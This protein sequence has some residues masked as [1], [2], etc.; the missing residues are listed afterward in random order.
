METPLS[1]RL[2]QFSYYLIFLAAFAFFLVGLNPTFY[3]DDSPETITACVTLGIPHPPGYPLFT[4]LGRLFSLLPVGHYPFRVNLFSTVLAASVCTLLYGFLKHPLKVSPRLA[5]PLALLWAVGATT[6]PAA[7]SAKTGVYQFTTF[8]LIAILWTLLEN[9][10]G[11]AAFL[12]GLSLAHHWM[13]LLTFLPGFGILIYAQWKGKGEEIEIK[14]ICYLIV[15]FLLGLSVYLCMPL[16]ALQHPWLN[17]GNPSTWHNFVYDFLRRQYLDTSAGWGLGVRLE[18][19][20]EYLKTAFLEFFGLWVAALGG[21]ALAFFREKLRAASFGALWL[22]LVASV[23]FYMALPREQFFLI[24][25]YTIPAHVFILLFLAWGLQIFLAPWEEGRRVKAEK[26]LA[27]VLALW[28]VALGAVRFSHDRQTYY[29]YGYDYVLNGYKTVPHN[30]LYFCKGDPVV[31]PS[32]YIQWIDQ[33]RQDLVVIGVDGLPMEWVR[34]NLAGFHPGLMVPRTKVPIGLESIPSLAAFFVDQNKFLDL[35]FSFNKAENGFLPDIKTVPYGLTLKGFRPGVAQTLDEGLESLIWEGMRLR[36]LND[37]RFPADDRT[38]NSIIRDYAAYR[39]ELGIFYE[40]LGDATKARLPKFPQTQDL[41]TITQDYEKSLEN[42]R[43]AEQWDPLNAQYKFNLGNAFY[44][45]EHL[46]EA[47]QWFEKATQLN[48]D[49]TIAYFNWAI[50]TLES[51]DFPK[52][53]E[54]FEKV[55]ALQPNNDEA[56][57]A[58]DYLKQIGH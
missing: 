20:W 18:Q 1:R 38:R 5:A 34:W 31:F 27:G 35:Y 37:P 7:L 51:G 25:N 53:R 42:F 8:F 36:H 15:F 57:R 44:H 52:A 49:Y 48:P 54:L 28:L 43:W 32:W 10:L 47:M 2:G 40:D 4:L 23:V 22:G 12:I 9:K 13:T 6:Y 46:P 17:W 33:K 58:L 19:V 55:H 3:V 16:R 41:L 14:R 26:I 24:S 45:T 11:L 39:N 50:T 30:A 56:L 21:L 29:T